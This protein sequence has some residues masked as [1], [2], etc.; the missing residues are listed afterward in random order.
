MP[1][2]HGQDFFDIEDNLYIFGNIY[3]A[4]KLF[5]RLRNWE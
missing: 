4:L 3:E 1:Q 2:H 5:E